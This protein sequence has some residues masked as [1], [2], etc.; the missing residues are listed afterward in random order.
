MST[1]DVNAQAPADN[2]PATVDRVDQIRDI[3]LGPSRREQEDRF[4]RV[5]EQAAQRAKELERS[6]ESAGKALQKRIDDRF[7]ELDRKLDRLSKRVDETESRLGRNL[8]DALADQQ[9][10]MAM[11]D[12][13]L[14]EELAHRAAELHSETD[15]VRAAL[16]AAVGRLQRDKTGSADLG[17]LLMGLAMQLKGE[18]PLRTLEAAV[19][20]ELPAA[21]ADA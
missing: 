12:E 3:L 9:S 11:M 1:E 21:D 14:R 5:E 18:D 13:G 2:G 8:E 17:D 6:L 15:E 7:E 20:G 4:A 16:S 10:R 19:G